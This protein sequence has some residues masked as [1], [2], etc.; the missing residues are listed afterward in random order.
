[1]NEALAR[2]LFDAGSA[3]GQ[4]ASSEDATYDI[5]GV[6][7][8]SK[9]QTISEVDQPM[10]YR[11][12]EQNLG[13]A[14][15]PVGFSLLVHYQGNAA[16]M[17]AALRSEIH[18]VDP[19]LAVFN[20]TTIE[21]HLK[22][23]L[24]LPRLSATVFGIFGIAGLLRAAVGLY[25][26]MSYSTSTRTRE[27]GIRLAMGATR[28]NVLRL[29]VSQGMLLSCIALGIGMPLALAASK[30]ASGV[31]YGITSRDWMTFTIVPCSWH[32]RA[33]GMLD[34]RE[35]RGK[36]RTPERIATRTSPVS[37]ARTCQ[38]VCAA[39]LI[40][41]MDVATGKARNLTYRP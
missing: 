8:N 34:S 22:D 37:D 5:V 1:M 24:L 39:S 2:R 16:Q 20:D 4:R 28:G 33:V 31:L 11:S 35:P 40:S 3:L 17:A 32:S 21:D 29:V 23:A 36:R 25:G 12:L 15:P 13:S 26:V 14:A 10:L 6:V 7:R 41:S 9:S 30:V 18:S 27:I 19:S 38:R